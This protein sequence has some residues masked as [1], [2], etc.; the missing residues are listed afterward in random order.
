MGF[1]AVGRFV[2]NDG[3]EMRREFIMKFKWSVIIMCI[4]ASAGFAKA[5]YRK[6]TDAQ[7]RVIDAKVISYDHVKGKV[8]IERKGRGGSTTVPT[9]IFS[10]E[11]REYIIAWS[12]NQAFLD[13]RFL[14]VEIGRK[15]KKNTKKSKTNY[16]SV[17]TAYDNTF[18]LELKN[19]SKTDFKDIQFE[20]VIYYTQEQHTNGKREKKE[21]KGTLYVKKNINLPRKS[22]KEM[23]TENI[24]ITSYREGSYSTGYVWPPLDGEVHGIIIKMGMETASGETIS[25]IILFP[26]GFDRAWTPKT[27]D[28]QESQ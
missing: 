26:Q 4:V 19:T 17:F 8:T 21:R 27:T 9:T 24:I 25:R 3:D 15:R 28:V 12:Q 20:Y 18:S 7:G 16:D 6:F 5:E 13:K 14:K 22:S 2:R 10:K 11:D 23:V 1:F